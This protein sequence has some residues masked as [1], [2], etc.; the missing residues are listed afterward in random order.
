MPPESYAAWL[1]SY[2]WRRIYGREFVYAGPLFIH[3]LSHLWIDF[4]GIRDAYM[5]ERGSD[6]FENSRHAT[7]VQRNMP[8]AIRAADP[9]YGESCWGVTASDGPGPGQ[10]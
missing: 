8:S 10:T 3:Q 7:Y 4:R 2:R 1:K 6:Y 9:G 5:R